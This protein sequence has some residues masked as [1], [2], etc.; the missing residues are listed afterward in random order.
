VTDGQYRYIRNYAP[1]RPWGQHVAYAWQ[2]KGY[3][4]WERAHAARTFNDPESTTA[5]T[6]FRCAA[7]LPA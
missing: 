4:A 5:H 2:Q 6:G 3:Q 7:A 1:H